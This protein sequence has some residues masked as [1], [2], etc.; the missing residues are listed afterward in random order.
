[1]LLV[2]ALVLIKPGWI[3]D[4]IGLALIALTLASQRWIGAHAT[5]PEPA[6]GKE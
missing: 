1:M 3:T 4:L 5:A 6:P 2:A